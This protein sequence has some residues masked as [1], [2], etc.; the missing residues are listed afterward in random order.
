MAEVIIKDLVQHYGD[1]VAIN[2]VSLQV[3]DGELV[4]LLGPSGCGK[5]T[6]LAALAGLEKPTSGRIVVGGVD[7]FD[8]SKGVYLAPEE[9]NCGL[10]FQSYALWPHMTV[11]DNCAFALKLR[12]VSSSDQK[13]RVMESLELVEMA[14][15]AQRFPFQLSGG[16]QQ[17][18]ALARTLAY[19][20]S[21]LLLDEPL[22]NLDAKLRER[23]RS[24]LRQ[25]Q[26][27]VGLTTIFVTHDQSEA[28]SMSDRVALLNGGRIV[29][30][31]SPTEIYNR[32]ATPFVADFI[33]S[34]A[35]MKCRIA[36]REGHLYT[37][38]LPNDQVVKLKLLGDWEAGHDV[39]VSI[40]PENIEL[41]GTESPS[42]GRGLTGHVVNQS[43]L[44][45][46]YECDF[47]F[48][49]TVLRLETKLDT[50]RIHSEQIWAELADIEFPAFAAS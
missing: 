11:Y 18:V 7:F 19:E 1:V 9:R 5:S 29:Q 42:S 15:Y 43:Y 26:Q 6:T 28:L 47:R 45:A 8:S 39:Q 23:A 27:K 16:Q 40:R 20:P 13:K 21:I 14:E 4:S 36:Q 12:K 50:S 25:L 41:V 35:L 3:N 48:G 22:S 37:L 31:D 24:W 34:G 2:G 44:G 33:G 46:R 32:P 30:F 10:V 17:R 49:T 38:K